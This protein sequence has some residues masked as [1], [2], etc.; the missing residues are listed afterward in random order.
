MPSRKDNMKPKPLPKRKSPRLSEYDYSLTGGYFFTIVTHNRTLLFGDIVDGEMVLNEIGKMIKEEWL[1]LP[2][3]FPS[4]TLDEFIVMPNHIHGILFINDPNVGEGLVPSR[5]NIADNSERAT[6]RVSP[7][8]PDIISAFKSITTNRY[9]QCVKEQG[10]PPFDKHLW[11]RS[12]YA[13]VIRD[14]VELD[15]LRQ[16]IHHNAAKWPQDEENP[17]HS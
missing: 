12:F 4:I 10:W 17:I 9:I 16:Y 15:N 6:T 5:D 2:A 14:D 7:T 3:R 1:A 8:L 11:Q 13:R